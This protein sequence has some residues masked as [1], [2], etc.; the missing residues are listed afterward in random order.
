[1]ASEMRCCASSALQHTG[2]FQLC[3]ASMLLAENVTL[4]ISIESAAAHIASM[5]DL[6]HR[7]MHACH[8]SSSSTAGRPHTDCVSPINTSAKSP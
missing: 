2:S 5:H 1:M 6:S 4:A 3:C 8:Y 7:T